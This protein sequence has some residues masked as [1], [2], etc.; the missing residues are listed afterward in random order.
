MGREGERER[1]GARE[2][3][4][5]EVGGRRREGKRVGID[6][7]KKRGR[8]GQG[9]VEGRKKERETDRKGLSLS[10]PHTLSPFPPLPL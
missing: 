5:E 3:A 2:G 10:L 4:R 1:E 6:G 7:V 9:E 8:E